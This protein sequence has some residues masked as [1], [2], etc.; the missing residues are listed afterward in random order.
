MCKYHAVFLTHCGHVYTCGSGRDG[1]LGSGKGNI[2]LE[3]HMV[4][5]E[6]KV[7]C[8]AASTHHSVFVLANGRV[9]CSLVHLYQ[10]SLWKYFDI[11][12][13]MTATTYK[14]KICDEGNV[15]NYILFI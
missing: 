2:S 13:L 11:L 9:S 10:K 15:W 5:L 12:F 14:L 1:Q 7:H 6:C 3:P 8:I 4:D